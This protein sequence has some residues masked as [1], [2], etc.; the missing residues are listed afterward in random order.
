MAFGPDAGLVLLDTDALGDA[1]CGHHLYHAARADL[2]RRRNRPAEALDA[3]ERAL[4]LVVNASER[5]YLDRRR[6]E[7][8]GSLGA[9]PPPA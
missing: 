1:L 9:L 7:V 4:S 8:L 3:Y 5:R 2:L 6:L